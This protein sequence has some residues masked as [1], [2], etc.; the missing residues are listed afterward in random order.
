ML[1]IGF[2]GQQCALIRYSVRLPAPVL[3]NM[4]LPKAIMYQAFTFQNKCCTDFPFH[5]MLW[6][7]IISQGLTIPSFEQLGEQMYHSFKN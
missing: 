5:R 3:A 2:Q 7:P 4:H 6:P 1:Q